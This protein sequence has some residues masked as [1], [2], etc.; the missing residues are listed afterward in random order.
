MRFGKLKMFLF[1]NGFIAIILLLYFGSWL[2]SSTATATIISPYNANTIHVQ[3]AVNG[4]LYTGT[5][6]RSE[7][8]FSQKEIEVHY[9]L[10]D[11][12]SSRVNS[13]MGLYAEPLAWWFVFLLA[14][15]MLL[16]MTN[17]VFSKGTTFQLQKKFPW[18]SMDEYFPAPGGGYYQ[19]RQQGNSAAR[20]NLK[21]LDQ[22][23]NSKTLT[24]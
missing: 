19:R 4:K 23:N 12:S 14:S 3:Y 16:L 2:V 5:H 7:I 1:L 6:L 24:S 8:P 22:N 20:K 9:F 18:I 11:P 21:R 13:F 15:G 17:T 10:F